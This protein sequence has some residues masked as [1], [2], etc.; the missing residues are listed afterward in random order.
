MEDNT[1]LTANNLYTEVEG[2]QGKTLDLG[3][4]QTRNLI[5]L[6]K[7]RF[8]S[9]ERARLGDESR[10]LNSYQ[11]F[12]GLYGKK[13]KFRESEKSRVFIKVT[14]TKTVAA[15]GQLIDV[16]FGTGEFPISVK[17]T[18]LPEGIAKDAHIQLNQPGMGIE[19]PEEGG[20]DVSQV[21]VEPNPFDVGYEG[22]GKVLRPGATFFS[23]ENFLSSLEDNYTDKDGNIVL[24]EGRRVVGL[25]Q[26]SPAQEAARN[27]EKLIHDQLEESNGISELR[28][29]LFE[30]AMLGTGI[31]KGF[32]ST[33]T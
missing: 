30:A 22:D 24:T 32:G 6:I 8:S 33:G 27:M 2:E 9:A 11:N 20:I 26:V 14:K 5:G 12:R 31:L 18:R 13:V 3:E 16:L 19:G 21:P 28:N 29:S 4:D 7:N 25:P 17:E 10:W 23:G 15:Y 1:F